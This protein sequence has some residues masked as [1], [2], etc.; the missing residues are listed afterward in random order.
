MDAILAMLSPEKAAEILGL[1][2]EYNSN[3]TA[4]AKFVKGCDKLEGVLQAELF[5]SVKY[6]DDY[7][8]VGYYHSDV[9]NRR[10]EKFWRHEPALMECA[11]FLRNKLIEIMESDGL[12]W[13]KYLPKDEK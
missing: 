7:P 8:P 10:R 6:W 9:I 3:E 11:E 2:K 1:W 13:K 12:D 4:E 5:G